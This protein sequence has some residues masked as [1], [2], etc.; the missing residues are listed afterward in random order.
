LP[1]VPQKKG[2][3]SEKT[4]ED[5]C[6]IYKKK[7]DFYERFS[8]KM[9][10]LLL[11]LIDQEKIE[12]SQIDCR[13]KSVESF[14]KKI[15]SDEKAYKNPLEDITD[16][17]GIRIV[18]YY[19]EDADRIGEIIEKE[20]EIDRENSVNKADTLDPDRFGYLSV[21][22]VVSLPTRRQRLTEWKVFSD[23]KAE[24]QVRT[25][26]QHAWAAI[27]HKIRYKRAEEVP[28][29]LRRELFRLSALLELADKEFSDLKKRTSEVEER[30][31]KDVRKGELKID[32]NL[33][34][35]DVYFESNKHLENWVRIAEKIGF[36]QSDQVSQGVKHKAKQ[37]LLRVLE[38]LNVKNI[39][40]LDN[41]LNAASS[42]GEKAL[43]T[44]Y[45]LSSKEEF[46][47]WAVPFD[48]IVFLLFYAYRDSLNESI[49]N[50]AGFKPEL[51][52]ALRNLMEM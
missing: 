29:D 51:S 7:I 12:L 46:Q 15:Q 17:A 43:R 14:S 35:L 22:Y 5:W 47:P 31:T 28:K 39:E 26:L 11:E 3:K 18:T 34:S 13:A 16:L 48:L 32:I 21:H 19:T 24:I 10:D 25:V 6:E 44:I 37:R 23:F 50:T 27:D 9:T 1:R 42:R 45:S 33:N 30:Y 20:F 49:I 41:F 52:Q 36:Q 8:E 38:P 40:E 2:K 4:L